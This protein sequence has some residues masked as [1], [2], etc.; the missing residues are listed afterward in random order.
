MSICYGSNVVYRAPHGWYLPCLHSLLF[1]NLFAWEGAIAV[2]RD[3]DAGRFGSHRYITCVPKPTAATAAFLCF[4]FLANE[5]LDL[6]RS[7]SPG[8]A[9][10]NRTLGLS[11]LERIIVSVPALEEQR[12]FDSL[13][14]TDTKTATYSSLDLGR[15]GRPLAVGSLEGICRGALR[16]ALSRK[17]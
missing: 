7:A 1:S 13:Q 14:G 9:L 6:I 3:E 4:Y 10:R 11:A 15:T 12:W 2:A 8:G 17:L 5:G 16:H